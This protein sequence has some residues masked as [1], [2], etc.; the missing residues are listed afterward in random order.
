MSVQRL[1]QS[2]DTLTFLLIP[3]KEN[4]VTEEDSGR[5]AGGTIPIVSSLAAASGLLRVV[6]G[7]TEADLLPPLASEPRLPRSYI[8]RQLL[9]SL[10]EH[11]TDICFL[12]DR[13]CK[14]WP[15][16]SLARS[17]VL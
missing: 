7:D 2:T 11:P 13:V 6:V 4:G 15:R 16:P 3:I 9:P 8:K 17:L 1:V 12:H 10:L 5:H 14:D